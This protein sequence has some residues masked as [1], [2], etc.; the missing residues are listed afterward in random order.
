MRDKQQHAQHLKLS[1]S[2]CCIKMNVVYTGC[3]M[4]ISDVLE[5]LVTHLCILRL[6]L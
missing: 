6:Q 1:G 2:V 3:I 5:A 4:A